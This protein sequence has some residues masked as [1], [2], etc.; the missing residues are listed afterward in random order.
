M[1]YFPRQPS[2]EELD[3]PRLLLQPGWLAGKMPGPVE[4]LLRML[5][6]SSES[7][8]LMSPAVSSAVVG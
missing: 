4:S 1:I 8:D 6:I 7:T 2:N 5:P 3:L